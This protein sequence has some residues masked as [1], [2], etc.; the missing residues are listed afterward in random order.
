[1]DIERISEIT[2]IVSRTTLDV[3]TK[4]ATKSASSFQ[5]IFDQALHSVDVGRNNFAI[6][7]FPELEELTALAFQDRKSLQQYLPVPL[8]R[9]YDN[10]TVEKFIDCV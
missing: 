9:R 5:G 10:T 3:S 2:D 8:S 6:S 4:P 1:M 7:S